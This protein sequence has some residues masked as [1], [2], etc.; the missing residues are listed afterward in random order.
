MTSPSG[1][2]DGIHLEA[3]ERGTGCSACWHAAAVAPQASVANSG[4][5][6]VHLYEQESTTLIATP[7]GACSKRCLNPEGTVA[8]PVTTRCATAMSVG[9]HTA[10]PTPSRRSF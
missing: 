9:R 10:R 7:E 4:H 6:H 3:A 2:A 1:A 8:M 5:P